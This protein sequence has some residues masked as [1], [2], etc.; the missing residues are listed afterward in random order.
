MLPSLWL[1][2]SPPNSLQKHEVAVIMHGQ[3]IYSS[4]VLCS[5]DGLE[6]MILP[7]QPLWGRDHRPGSPAVSLRF[8]CMLFPLWAGSHYEA[9]AGSG[10]TVALATSNSL[11]SCLNFPGAR[12]IQYVHISQFYFNSSNRDYNS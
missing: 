8:T 6:L 2:L 4:Q 3:S 7:S 5:P 12:I 11:F 1:V 10:L 9:L